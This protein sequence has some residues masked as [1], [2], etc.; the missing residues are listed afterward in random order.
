[1]I[2]IGNSAESPGGTA[3][4]VVLKMYTQLVLVPTSCIYLSPSASIK[5]TIRVFWGNC[6]STWTTLRTQDNISPRERYSTDWVPWGNGTLYIAMNMHMVSW[7]NYYYILDRYISVG[8]RHYMLRLGIIIRES[9][10]CS[11]T[12][13]VPLGLR[14]RTGVYIP[15]ESSP[16]TGLTSAQLMIDRR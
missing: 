12:A 9:K 3:P 5:N 4:S 11:S 1:M 6:I 16:S 2:V 15:F 13:T 7:G 8:D 14:A 10:F